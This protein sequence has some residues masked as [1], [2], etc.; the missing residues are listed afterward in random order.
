MF[1]P[2]NHSNQVREGWIELGKLVASKARTLW[3]WMHQ[4]KESPTFHEQDEFDRVLLR[5]LA[6]RVPA[7]DHSVAP[8]S[9]ALNP[10]HL[11]HLSMPL[12]LV[13]IMFGSGARCVGIDPEGDIHVDYSDGKKR[14]YIAS[15]VF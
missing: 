1:I 4:T 5:K 7:V 15:E 13:M 10:L 3:A 9:A 14:I 6:A 8:Q 2:P 11:T 12:D